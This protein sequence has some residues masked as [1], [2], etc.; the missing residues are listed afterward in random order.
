MLNLLLFLLAPFLVL[1]G[2]GNVISTP[3]A[4][5]GGGSVSYLTSSACWAPDP[6]DTLT[7]T[8]EMLDPVYAQFPNT[9]NKLPCYGTGEFNGLSGVLGNYTLV[10]RNT[11]LI[12]FKTDTEGGPYYGGC[13]I[14]GSAIR[15]IGNHSDGR[16]IWWADSSYKNGQLDGL[17]YIEIGSDEKTRTFDIYTHDRWLDNPPGHI[18]ACFIKGGIV[19]VVEENADLLPPQVVSF[20]N[21]A[22]YTNSGKR[23]YLD[24][25][26]YEENYEQ[27]APLPG[28]TYVSATIPPTAL[29]FPQTMHYLIK[30]EAA[31]EALPKKAANKGRIGTVRGTSGGKGYEYEVYFHAGEFYFRNAKDNSLFIYESSRDVPP[32]SV[33]RNASLQLGVLNFR[34]SNEWSP[35]T[36]ACKPAI[37]LYPERPMELSVQ[38]I[39]D[40]YLTQSNPV[41]N[42][43]WNVKAEPDGSIYEIKDQKSKIKNNYLYYEAQIRNLSVPKEGWVI[44]RSKIKDQISKIL[45]RLGLNEKE[46]TDFLSYWEPKLTKKPY[47][48]V[49]LVSKDELNR[50]ET[51]LFSQKPDT[52]IRVRMIFE[53]L[54]GPAQ[55]SPLLLPETPK[56]SGFT[57]VDWGGGEVGGNC[58]DG[59]VHQIEIK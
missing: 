55:V 21:D 54:D 13:K 22:Q 44:E 2:A 18:K 52:L 27:F 16:K 34:V 31:D 1:A 58:E 50:K 32:S 25:A 19:P 7:I 59:V 46:R 35:F 3:V 11:T 17:V 57:V 49:T 51:L 26:G 4:Q 28:K 36:P 41:Y 48:F 30:I 53:G 37:Y 6:S 20:T 5:Q 15:Y 10:R 56:R 45:L 14:T 39:P 43:G 47:Y 9:D 40:G 42:D 12:K 29:L 33:E 38:I 8:R 24:I 23:P